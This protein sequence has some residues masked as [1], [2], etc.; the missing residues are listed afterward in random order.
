MDPVNMR[1]LREEIENKE[2]RV[3][4]LLP[5]IWS[6]ELKTDTQTNMCTNMFIVALLTKVKRQ[7]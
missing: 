1:S 4:V 7:K 5:S 6:K 3:S 2:K